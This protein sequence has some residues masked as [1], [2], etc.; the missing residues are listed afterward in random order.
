[1]REIWKIVPSEPGVLVSNLGRVVLQPSY[2]P[3]PN[4]V[5]RAYLPVPS[6]GV[7]AKS[8]KTAKHKYYIVMVKRKQGGRRQFTRKV[9]QLVC[10]AFHGPKPFPNAVVIHKDENGLNNHESNLKWGTQKENLNAKGFIEYCKSRTGDN[11]PIIK[12]RKKKMGELNDKA[13]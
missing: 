4:G 3:M 7:I 13:R 6:F 12:A 9:H 8:C 1:M 2:A 10:E 11:S 5:Y